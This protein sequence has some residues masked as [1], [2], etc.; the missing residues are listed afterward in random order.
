M[1][2][3]YFVYWQKLTV[4]LLLYGLFVSFSLAGDISLEYIGAQIIPHDYKFENTVVGGLSALDYDAAADHFVAI[5]DDR[6]QKGPA[7]FYDLK[8]DYDAKAFR[9]AKITGVH[10]MKRPDGSLFPKPE[11]FGKSSVDPEALA[12]APGGQGYFWTSEGHAKFGVNPFVREMTP[13]G[14]YLRD[15]TVPEKF[16]PGKDRGIRDNLAFEGLSVDADGRTILVATEGPL[17]QDGAEPTARHGAVIRLIQFDI[18]TGRALDEYAYPVAPVHR[19]S[20]PLGKFSVNGVSAI[21][22]VGGDRYIVVERSFAVGAGLSVRLYLITLRGATDISSMDS[23]KDADYQPVKKQLLLDT[24]GLGITIDN[25]EGISFGRTLG[26][27]RRSL[28]LISDDNFRAQ[29]VTQ[30]LLF[31]VRIPPRSHQK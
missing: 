19:V 15:F 13:D 25:L 26:D 28:L 5:S 14:G 3:H 4:S 21:L 11:L 2:R 27:G 18:A 7:R 6:S 30:I 1:Y 23:L 22:A 10:F 8:L 31:A 12:F 24:G 17:L 20:F 29:Q 9:G 16:L